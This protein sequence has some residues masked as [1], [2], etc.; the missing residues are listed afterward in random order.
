MNAATAVQDVTTHLAQLSILEHPVEQTSMGIDAA[1]HGR[2]AAIALSRQ[3]LG[4]VL[5]TARASSADLS[6]LHTH[7]ERVLAR[8]LYVGAR[9][10]RNHSPAEITAAVDPRSASAAWERLGAAATRAH[11]AWTQS[12]RLPSGP[13]GRAAVADI[14]V[15]ALGVAHL[16]KR[17]LQAA[18]RAGADDVARDLL[19][20]EGAGLNLAARSVIDRFAAGA[21]SWKVAEPQRVERLAVLPVT[22]AEDL[23][24]GLGRLHDLLSS[25]VV[26]T[27]QH[28]LMLLVA[29]VR[30]SSVLVEQ[31]QRAARATGDA[32]YS[33]LASRLTDHVSRLAGSWSREDRALVS[34]EPSDPRPVQQA[35]ECL[36][37]LAGVALPVASLEVAAEAVVGLS[38]ATVVAV[39]HSLGSRT[40]ATHGT[41]NDDQRGLVW[42]LL[43]EFDRPPFL[44]ALREVVAQAAA[45]GAALSMSRDWRACQAA[46]A[47]ART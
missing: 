11:V 21:S 41:R 35:G 47:L 46:T 17:L 27:P 24:R 2:G 20:A 13:E 23:P 31:S 26:V 12:P 1:L 22:C 25:G 14:A 45:H 3:V 39:Q 34:L 19:V 44:D 38:R 42:R 15:I 16:D 4:D 32:V 37:Q 10:A 33:S 30:M 9:Q 43:D 18:T 28:T 29:Q 7:P 5:G 6:T 40:W 36:R 8:A